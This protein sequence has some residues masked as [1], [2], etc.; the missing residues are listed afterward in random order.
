MSKKRGFDA[1][2]DDHDEPTIGNYT[3]RGHRGGARA[4]SGLYDDDDKTTMLDG[5]GRDDDDQDGHDDRTV[6]FGKT[7]GD[8]RLVMSDAPVGWVV[9]TKG[10]GITAAY[11][12]TSGSNRIGRQGDNDIVLHHGDEGISRVAHARITYDPRSRQFYL[13]SGEGRGL[14]YLVGQ[15]QPVMAPTALE[16][17]SEFEIGDTRLRFVPLCSSAFDWADVIKPE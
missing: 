2:D 9:V 7:S 5:M 8:N 4:G 15:Q 14:V 16:S 3:P 10:P 1:L 11:P 6:M 17:G 13:H 12:V